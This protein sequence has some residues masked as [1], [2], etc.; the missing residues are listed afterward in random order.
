MVDPFNVTDYNRT[1]RQLEEFLFFCVFVAGKNAVQTAEKTHQFYREFE[2]NHYRFTQMNLGV[3]HL[4][5]EELARKFRL[6][7][8]AVLSK[9][10]K[11]YVNEKPDLRTI[12]TH[13]LMEY[14]GIG[15]KTARFFILHSRPDVRVA[16]LDTHILKY[17]REQGINAPKSTPGVPWQY[18]V[19]EDIFLHMY[20]NYGFGTLAEFDLYLWKRYRGGL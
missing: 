20:D 17:L 2:A 18:K 15:P 7:K 6:G 12:T 1:D 13:E 9:F 11:K 14:P 16:V 3:Q 8:Y 5:L 10:F 19:L 4:L